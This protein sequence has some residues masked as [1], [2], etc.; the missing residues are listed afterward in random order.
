MLSVRNKLNVDLGFFNSYKFPIKK[1][2]YLTNT[3]EVDI[4]YVVR[5]P[6]DGKSHQSEF[7]IGNDR[8]R[9]E[10]SKEA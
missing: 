10:R 3:W 2:V 1:T 5:V 8:G 4:N 6:G 7:S 9:L